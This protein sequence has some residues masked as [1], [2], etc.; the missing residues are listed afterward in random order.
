MKQI[1]FLV[2]FAIT[3]GTHGSA[4]NLQQGNQLFQDFCAVCHGHLANGKG[5]MASA[6][7]QPP[8][9]LR[10]LQQRNNNV[11]PISDVLQKIDG[12]SPII[13]HGSQMPVYGRFF[14][15]KGVAMRDENGMLTMTSQPLID[16][17]TWLATIQEPAQ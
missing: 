15:G 9:D 10:K 12:R 17:V 13:S 14:E 8:A 7:K 11:F 5:P 16:I 4:Q 2:L 3:F 6:L 1:G